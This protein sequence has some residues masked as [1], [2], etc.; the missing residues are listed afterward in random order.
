MSTET[1][2]PSIPA[3]T[4]TNLTEVARAVKGILDVREGRVGDKLDANVTFRDLVD[5]GIA[6]IASGASATCPASG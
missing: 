5:V 2:I 3:V 6:R 1:K 4:Q